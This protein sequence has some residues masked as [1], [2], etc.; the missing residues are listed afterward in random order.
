MRAV[1]SRTSTPRCCGV[2]ERGALPR[3]PVCRGPGVRARRDGRRMAQGLRPRRRP[4]C[5][6]T[7][8]GS[9]VHA[10]VL[11]RV[12]R[13]SRHDRPRRAG[14]NRPAWPTQCEPRCAGSAL[15]ASSR[16][17]NDRAP[18]WALRSARHHGGRA[19]FRGARLT[20]RAR[21]VARRAPPVAGEPRR[22]EQ[23]R[24][25][26]RQAEAG[27]RTATRPC[28]N[29]RAAAPRPC[30]AAVTARR[31][32]RPVAHRLG[33]SP[34]PA[35]Q[36]RAHGAVPHRPSSWNSAATPARSGSRTTWG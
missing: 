27:A 12:P 1:S 9:R 32:A 22:R 18:A 10:Q 34:L 24:W 7:T 28:A 20:L 3:R 33:R 14:C 11:R 23:R 5:T 15:H 6:R 17:R 26:Q 2:L 8:I 21:A 30:H 36:R 19:L 31:R 35:R 29:T 16:I 25:R 4:S 13:P